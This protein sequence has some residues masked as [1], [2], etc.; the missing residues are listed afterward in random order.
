MRLSSF[1][2]LQV[3]LKTKVIFFFHAESGLRDLDHA[4]FDRY[5]FIFS[6][7]SDTKSIG[8]ERNGLEDMG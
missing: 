2:L 6:S 5:L 8:R 7:Y 3:F 1:R 4:H